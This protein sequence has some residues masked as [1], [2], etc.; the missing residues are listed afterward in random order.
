MSKGRVE[1][2]YQ[3]NLV[4][5][6]N[7]VSKGVKQLDQALKELKM[8]KAMT[9]DTRKELDDLKQKIEKFRDLSEK[10]IKTQTDFSKIK[11]DGDEIV[12]LYNKIHGKTEKLS[13]QNPRSI[14]M[15]KYG[16]AIKKVESALK[17]LDSE[18]KKYNK[19][20]A[21]QVEKQEKAKKKLDD[22]TKKYG[23]GESSEEQKKYLSYQKGS[24]TR[25][26]NSI[27][28]DIETGKISKKEGNA[29]IA[30][31]N[32]REKN[33]DSGSAAKERQRLEQDYNQITQSLINLKKAQIGASSDTNIVKLFTQIR[34]EAEKLGISIPKDITFQGLESF[35][36]VIES[37]PEE[38]QREIAEEL[39]KFS[40]N[41]EKAAGGGKVLGTQ[42]E[43]NAEQIN[44]LVSRTKD[45]DILRSRLE[46]VFGMTGMLNIF[47]RAIQSTVNTIKELDSVMTETAV[48]TDYTVS[49]MWNKIDEYADVASKLGVS[50]KGVYEVTTLLY[51]MGMN[52]SQAMGAG[53]EILKMARI[54]GMDYASAT[55]AMVSAL[56]GFNMEVNEINA[57][58]VNDI[59]SRIA[60]ISASNVQELST[61]MSKTA[62]IA[63]NAGMDIENTTALLAQGIERTRESAET[64]GTALK[65][66]IARFNEMKKAPS[67]IE[68]VDGEVV[69][70]NKIETALR[71]AGIALRDVNGEIRNT[72]NVLFELSK[73][74]NILSKN[75]RAYIATQAAGS[76]QQSRFIAMISD[77]QRLSQ[78]QEEAVN[79]AGASNKQFEKTLD[80]LET[81]LQNLR[82]QVDTF[83]TQ[84]MDSKLLKFLVD[85]GKDLA[86]ISNKITNLPGILGSIS[87]VALGMGVFKGGGKLIDLVFGS[88]A[89]NNG[90]LSGLGLRMGKNIFGGI[91]NT[92]IKGKNTIQSLLSKA[93]DYKG[94]A[95][96]NSLAMNNYAT[97]VGDLNKQLKAGRISE[98]VY[99]AQI[100]QTGAKLGLNA[101]S[102]QAYNTV[103][104][105]G[106][107]IKGA[108]ILLQKEDLAQKTLEIIA[109]ESLTAEQK[110]QAI[111]ELINQGIKKEGIVL[112]KT[113]L[114][115]K[116]KSY[117][118]LLL[119]SKAT[120]EAAVAN[121][122][123]ASTAQAATQATNLFSKALY[124]IPFLGWILAAI[125]AIATL[126]AIIISSIRTT[127]ESIDNADEAAEQATSRIQELSNEIENLAD[128][129]SKIEELSDSFDDLTRGSVEWTSKLIENNQYLEDLV[130]KYEILQKYLA[131]DEQGIAY[132]KEGYEKELTNSL[133]NEYQLQRR[134]KISNE[135]EAA[136]LRYQTGEITYQEYQSAQKTYLSQGIQSGTQDYASVAAANS[137]SKNFVKEFEKAREDAK[138]W[139]KGKAG[140]GVGSYW[141]DDLKKIGETLGLWYKKDDKYYTDA[142][143]QTE[144]DYNEDD[145][146]E[147]IISN[148]TL[149][150]I[151]QNTKDTAN[152]LRQEDTYTQKLAAG[153]WQDITAKDIKE[154]GGVNQNTEKALRDNYGENAEKYF[155]DVLSY[156]SESYK[157]LSDNI[158]SGTHPFWADEKTME[159]AY[160]ELGKYFRENIDFETGTYKGTD[161]VVNWADLAGVNTFGGKFA[162]GLSLWDIVPVTE[163]NAK[164]QIQ[165]AALLSDNVYDKA[166]KELEDMIAWGSQLG[167]TDM[168]NVVSAW[169]SI[170][171]ETVKKKLK[172]IGEE[173]L[174]YE[175]DYGE[176]ITSGIAS[177]LILNQDKQGFAEVLKEYANSEGI[178]DVQEVFKGLDISITA[179][180]D[181]ILDYIQV[182]RNLGNETSILTDN[183]IKLTKGMTLSQEKLQEWYQTINK[184]AR[185]TEGKTGYDT[186]TKDEIEALVD[187]TA[188]SSDD[189]LRV[190]EDSYKVINKT[191]E[192]ITHYL[193]GWDAKI[194]GVNKGN[195]NNLKFVSMLS[196]EKDTNRS[197]FIKTG[198]AEG[199]DLKFGTQEKQDIYQVAKGIHEA[200]GVGVVSDT[201]AKTGL[202]AGQMSMTDAKT[203]YKRLL[204][205]QQ[206]LANNIT[207]KDEATKLWNKIDAQVNR[208]MTS[209]EA[210]QQALNDFISENYY[211]NVADYEAAQ[212]ASFLLDAGESG[213]RSDTSR[214][215]MYNS[216]SEAMRETAQ[217]ASQLVVNERNLNSVVQ[218]VTST[219]S[220]QNPSLAKNSDLMKELAIAI[221]DAQNGFET[222][223]EVISDCEEDLKN[224]GS[225]KYYQA[226][227][228]IA[229]AFQNMGIMGADSTWVGAN[230]EDIMDFYNGSA[231][232]ADR[233][234]KSLVKIKLAQMDNPQMA[235]QLQTIINGLTFDTEGI[236]TFTE[237][238]NAMLT[239]LVGKTGEHMSDIEEIFKSF[240]VDLEYIYDTDGKIT[241]VKAVNQLQIGAN[242]NKRET[243][244]EKANESQW[245]NSYDWLYNL[246]QKINEELRI[247]EKLEKRYDRILNNR[248]M[249]E[250]DVIAARE[251]ELQSLMK[252]LDLQT[253]MYEKRRGELATLLRDNK[254]LTKYAT[255][256][257]ENNMIQINWDKIN[258]VSD[259]TL[260]GR[261]EQFIEKLENAESEFENAFDSIEDI[262]DTVQDIYNDSRQN[263]LD[264]EN[265]VLEAVVNQYQ[266]E[267]DRLTEIDNSI[268]DSNSKLLDSIQKSIDAQRQ[269]RQNAETEENLTDKLNQL[270]YKRQDKT[271]SLTDLKSLE[272]E[273]KDSRQD[274]ID[275]L[276][277]QK[278]SELQK[279]NDEAAEQRQRQ[280][281]LMEGQLEQAKDQGLLWDE[282]NLLLTEGIYGS[283]GQINQNSK[284]V[285]ILQ[286][287]D[288]Y[289]GLSEEGR[290]NWLDELSVQYKQYEEFGKLKGLLSENL[291]TIGTR[292]E[293]LG[294]QLNTLDWTI[295]ATGDKIIQG[296]RDTIIED[297]GNND[298]IN[299][300]RQDFILKFLKENWDNIPTKTMISWIQG[301][302]ISKMIT[303]EAFKTLMGSI[304]IQGTG[305]K[306]QKTW[307]YQMYATGGLADFTGPAWLDGTKSRPELVLNQHD[308]QN[309][310]QLKDILSSIMSN[311]IPSITEGT[312]TANSNFEIN[313][314]VDKIANDYDVDRLVERVKK[315]IV[316]D[317]SYRNPVVLSLLR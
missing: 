125:A 123:Y 105:E 260:G 11:K 55:D 71:T 195:E 93:V 246:T 203:A 291:N 110:K 161:Q 165:K 69:D 48:V 38:K 237:T 149:E 46:Y 284:L 98:K 173:T 226:I 245:E 181:D 238:A 222:I 106:M 51:Q 142:E 310:I 108:D 95:K 112:E 25:K 241:G 104:S 299:L 32:A 35:R 44:N 304:K 127:Q 251:K 47:R 225:I 259:E 309:F 302:L 206:I 287:L 249:S 297:K 176:G 177:Y 66:V 209:P 248:R 150:K 172:N 216:S 202:G 131:Y 290:N 67:E 129:F 117:A 3:I 273:L 94:V 152:A 223:R 59:Y 278:I 154:H 144:L 122:G 276:V 214:D 179:T 217:K 79:S 289:N 162:S 208:E 157:E 140:G 191:A 235:L 42:L 137:F 317:S 261:I 13:K 264:F 232:A 57:Q 130:D 28:K 141:N 7:E 279:Q 233:L 116:L 143:F 27:Q 293:N 20:L 18:T 82:N 277:D 164:E 282:V 301:F 85:V 218:M 134:N 194:S 313:I 280:I 74:W 263:Y 306:G 139:L 96:N 188:I 83:L 103:I 6:I 315:D 109:N 271:S 239:T 76:R 286:Q 31:L 9:Q 24:I 212:N 243:Q 136:W 187:S 312:R 252:E 63:A 81:K 26:R 242:Y 21:N 68:A 22:F 267:I 12:R 15:D 205:Q 308:T 199:S 295:K 196:N 207:D 43:Q 87:K 158:S 115:I 231:S 229:Q 88:L 5:G 236:G 230:L 247:R 311:N 210:I 298:E 146:A 228:K 285:Q 155:N 163:D 189:V 132:F 29:K 178:K 135:Y 184:A 265:R 86:E 113:N 70:A 193:G 52:T 204:F 73:K 269:A 16:D 213:Y 316:E 133:Q 192:Q 19:D 220:K 90:K 64:I 288:K 292:L 174:K 119:G 107:G 250:K 92:F 294:S 120:R 256:D 274:Y 170:T 37:F 91:K 84:I 221:S 168:N 100:E 50:I 14:F 200:G 167:I 185:I 283:D 240:G 270:L 224:F 102:A 190:G 307:F 159:D 72:D 182:Q 198:S 148:K 257:F 99:A 305:P 101:V 77:Y 53:I 33:L 61:A 138:D 186:Y 58:K 258:K 183:F 40:A 197:Q 10:P 169:T 4:E 36:K 89:K 180:A 56:K 253:E 219:V 62:S 272:K 211:E 124:K 275:T 268:N 153:K 296:Y 175:Q 39:N 80:S 300:E 262:Y 254:D 145:M 227:D 49:D 126:T 34:S 266:L 111:Q 114:A 151:Q 54:A 147:R 8:P 244:K 41:A 45:M 23:K 30:E 201:E 121:L 156:V 97:V 166:N 78:F 281:E 128:T 1:L 118:A 303:K 2:D 75:T 234:Y 65:T 171:D 255:Y 160:I 17:S 60:A 314:N 215:K